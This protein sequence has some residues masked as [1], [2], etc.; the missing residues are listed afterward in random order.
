[1]SVG[2]TAARRPP[3]APPSAPQLD[4]GAQGGFRALGLTCD[5]CAWSRAWQGWLQS[6]TTVK[7]VGRRG[8]V[9]PLGLPSRINRNSLSRPAELV[10]RPL[11]R[12]NPTRKEGP[13]GEGRA[14]GVQRS[15]EE[16][17]RPPPRPQ[18]GKS[19]W[20]LWTFGSLRGFLGELLHLRGDQEGC[21]DA[22]LDEVLEGAQGVFA[23]SS[24][25][26]SYRP[27]AWVCARSPFSEILQEVGGRGWQIR[28]VAWSP[29]EE[30]GCFLTSCP[31]TPH[32]HPVSRSLCLIILHP[33]SRAESQVDPTEGEAEVSGQVNTPVSLTAE[34]Q[35]L[36]NSW[37]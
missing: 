21:C 26:K 1:M 25:P 33:G 4:P 13:Q 29:L 31:P 22:K 32:P 36:P 20:S 17:S 15:L 6:T 18:E 28:R 11:R 37:E 24:P 12:Q 14:P 2:L 10:Y 19:S 3:I 8:E 27:H 30:A 23:S 35:V 34:G 16:S 7:Q 9:D 5:V